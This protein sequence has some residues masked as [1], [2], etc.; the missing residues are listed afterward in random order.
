MS[1]MIKVIE[2]NLEAP[3]NFI[4]VDE[5]FFEL[6]KKTGKIHLK[7]YDINL[8]DDFINA[9]QSLLD[10]GCEGELYVRGEDN[11][12]S[13]YELNPVVSDCIRCYD[14]HVIYDEES[15]WTLDMLKEYQESDDME[16]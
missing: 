4:E 5:N 11:D 8:N 3:N 10:Q 13:K 16:L 2:Y 14:G 1:N 12:F 7:A 15:T 6:D 9:L